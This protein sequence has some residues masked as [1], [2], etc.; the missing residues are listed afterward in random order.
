MFEK[1]D[2]KQKRGREWPAKKDV[3]LFSPGQFRSFYFESI[4]SGGCENWRFNVNS[5]DCPFLSLGSFARQDNKRVGA[6]YE[7]H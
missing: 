4:D 1:T 3:Y 6:Q 5:F 7:G 2:N